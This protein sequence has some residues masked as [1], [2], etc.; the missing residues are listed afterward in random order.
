M[1]PGTFCIS[2][3]LL[4]GCSSP[5]WQK[6]GADEAMTAADAQSCSTKARTAPSRY[7]SPPPSAYG[8]P[9]VLA[10]E[11]TRAQFESNE[12]RGCMQ[13]KGYSAR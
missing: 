3:V 4:A 13:E 11:S 9:N 7:P 2:V 12:F 5:T 6:S 1:K 10:L 8:G